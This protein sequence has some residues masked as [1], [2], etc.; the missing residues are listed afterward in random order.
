VS[1]TVIESIVTLPGPALL[2]V[3]VLPAG[4]QPRRGEHVIRFDLRE[5][6]CRFDLPLTLSY[7]VSPPKAW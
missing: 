5:R 2:T 1:R 4:F 3:S 6:G 7:R